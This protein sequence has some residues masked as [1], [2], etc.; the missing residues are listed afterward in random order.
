VCSAKEP[1]IHTRTAQDSRDCVS[2]DCGPPDAGVRRFGVDGVGELRFSR[3]GGRR[4]AGV[5]PDP[6][7]LAWGYLAELGQFTS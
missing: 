7:P 3:D 5:Q 4:A 1:D 6:Q 2:P